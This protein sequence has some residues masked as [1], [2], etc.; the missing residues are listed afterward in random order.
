MHICSVSC[1]FVCVAVAVVVPVAIVVVVPVAVVVV[2]VVFKVLMYHLW[3]TD[4]LISGYNLSFQKL[5]IFEH[6]ASYCCEVKLALLT[7]FSISWKK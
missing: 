2:V 5:F 3:D 4:S 6:I 7:E 1:C